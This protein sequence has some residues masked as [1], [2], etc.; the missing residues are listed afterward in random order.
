[1]PRPQSIKM[2]AALSEIA[3]GK[4]EGKNIKKLQGR[5]GYRLRRGGFRAIYRK[6]ENGI[7]VLMIGPRG[8]IYK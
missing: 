4:V 2:H 7:E 8:G 6:G 3:E 5:E 1:M